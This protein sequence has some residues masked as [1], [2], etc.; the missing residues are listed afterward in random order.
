MRV[1]YFHH[2]LWPSASPST[3]FVT[4]TCLGFAEQGADFELVT[5]ANTRR[6]VREVLST[7]FGIVIPLPIRLLHAGPLRRM[8]VAVHLLAFLHFLTAPWDVLITRNLGFLPWALLL[9]QIRGGI[10]VLESHD[11]YSDPGL[12]GLPEGPTSRR[13]GRRERRW[14]PRVNGVITTS[15]P[16]RQYYMH[17]YPR[18]RFLAAVAGVKANSRPR[19]PRLVPGGVVGYVGTFD[20]VLND[21]DLMLEAFGKVP[22][23]GARLLIAGARNAADLATMRDR[24]ARHGLG[25]RVEVLPWQSPKDLEALKAR[26]DVGLAPLA[27]NGRNRG[28]TPLKVLEYLS[29][30][31]PVVGSDLPSIRDLLKDDSCGLVAAN[32]ADA[33]AA[34]ITRILSD[35]ALADTLSANCLARAEDL[36]WPRRAGRILEF[37]STLKSGR[38]PGASLASGTP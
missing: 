30:G 5:V 19:P 32:T 18:Q 25:A 23:A 35:A 13:Q 4:W 6:E 11:F 1:R 8:H 20:P 7:E 12:R 22:V 31:I 34:A 27:I 9:R 24:V 21:F 15:E 36:S 33:W 17:C 26:I 28:C 16:F 29:A 14:I 10:V 38:E 37:L 3:T 2:G